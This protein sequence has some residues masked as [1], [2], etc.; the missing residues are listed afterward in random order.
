[1]VLKK[2]GVINLSEI[3]IIITK[4]PF[5]LNIFNVKYIP[6]QMDDINKYI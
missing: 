2:I 5:V 4:L 6:I 3:F 1:M